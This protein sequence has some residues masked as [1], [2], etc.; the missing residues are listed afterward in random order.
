MFSWE[1]ANDDEDAL[2]QMSDEAER[3]R[4]E[5]GWT[6]SFPAE[7]HRGQLNKDY[8]RTIAYQEHLQAR[9]EHER[10]Q[11][12][13]VAVAP[14]PLNTTQSRVGLLEA[15]ASKDEL[16]LLKCVAIR[17]GVLDK[18]KGLAASAVKAGLSAERGNELLHLLLQLRDA[19]VSV[20]RA[21][22]QRHLKSEASSRYAFMYQQQNYCAKMI[23]DLNFLASMRALGQVLGVEPGRMK[24][25][26]FMMPT[27]IPE[28]DFEDVQ[29]MVSPP[30]F[31]F[32]DPV[33]RVAQA[34][35]YLVWCLLHLPEPPQSSGVCCSPSATSMASSPGK[36]DKQDVGSW[37]QRAE[38]QLR[39]L[40]MPMESTSGQLHLMDSSRMMKRKGYL[41]SLPRSPPKTLTDLMDTV[42]RSSTKFASPTCSGCFMFLDAYTTGVLYRTS[43]LE[44]EVLGS[45]GTPPHHIITLVAASVLILL[46]P[47]DRIPKD[48]SWMSCQKMLSQG[49]K[50][51]ERLLVFEVESVPAF[52]WKAL[53]PFLQNEHFH[54][55]FLVEYSAGAASLCAWILEVLAKAEAYERA[56]TRADEDQR[57]LLE[58]LEQEEF[59]ESMP[60]P[61]SPDT[62]L[63]PLSHSR[64]GKRVSIGNAEVL[65]IN[66][67]QPVSPP[68][69]APGGSRPVSRDMVSTVAS[70]PPRAQVLLRTSPWTHRGVTYFVSFF[71]ERGEHDDMLSIKMYEPM[72][73]VESQMF[74]SAEDLAMD[75]GAS[76][77]EFFQRREFGLLCDLIVSQLDGMMSG[78]SQSSRLRERY[79]PTSARR[80]ASETPGATP[81]LSSRSDANS[82]E[83]ELLRQEEEED[84]AA[85]RIQSLARQQSARRELEGL[86]EQ[87]DATVKIQCAVRQRQARDKVKHVRFAQ[88]RQSELRRDASATRIQSIARQKQAKKKVANMKLLQR[89]PTGLP[90]EVPPL[91]SDEEEEEPTQPVNP[92][93]DDE[94][95]PERPEA[96]MSYASELFEDDFEAEE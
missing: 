57:D 72:S 26:P 20:I 33:E 76:A 47:S 88:Q 60:I 24:Q 32:G 9:K 39:L 25:N 19:S 81:P 87:R 2:L 41:P 44:L 17:E 70:R 3:R 79:S 35:K 21:M 36:R 94:E 56:V 55:H 68:S 42:N 91:E 83:D 28:R 65:F 31:S 6:T 7:Y 84:A 16:E 85:I 27:P 40:S 71:L 48:L 12:M 63:P 18:L 64:S 67:N 62:A 34:E 14:S 15:S 52:K 5:V 96:S 45:H 53:R 58:E 43:A 80:L 89:T 78:G 86:R 46:S 30:R 69:T 93:Q 90:K 92:S 37:Q 51:I 73:S 23:S 4:R 54:P 29:T 61:S 75:F 11:L 77:R 95:Q 50:L 13:G 66:E 22:A 1:E 38:Q 74:V 8:E 49:K 82:L 59:N 10:Q